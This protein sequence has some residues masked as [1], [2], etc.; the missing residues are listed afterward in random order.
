MNAPTQD[1]TPTAHGVRPSTG[2][3]LIQ[4]IYRYLA[5]SQVEQAALEHSPKAR[6]ELVFQFIALV[7][8]T[9]ALMLAAHRVAIALLNCT[10]PAALALALSAGG[11]LHVIDRHF[12]ILNRGAAKDQRRQAAVTKAR[13]TSMTLIGIGFILLSVDTFH[14]DIDAYLATQ[15]TVIRHELMAAPEYATSVKAANDAIDTAG[16]NLKRAAE[17]RVAAT[18]AAAQAAE[19][20][21]G[22]KDQC[23]G[24]IVGNAEYIPKCGPRSRGHK[25]MADAAI[26]R[27]KAI[28]EELE[29]LG[30]VDSKWADANKAKA[31]INEKIDKQANH[32]V[33]GAA[34][35]IGAL[36]ALLLTNASMLL[37][38]AFS[39]CLGLLPDIA[40]WVAL[41]NSNFDALYAAA[42][43]VDH[44]AAQAATARARRDLRS[45]AADGLAPV[46]VRAAAV[47]PTLAAVSDA[48]PRTASQRGGM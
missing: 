40:I 25:T 34:P 23:E 1:P 29:Q 46:E 27:G 9:S 16:A 8:S 30:D 14:E 48:D 43:K 13:I 26:E 19:A 17:L 38:M 28:K 24:N 39:L 35:K 32:A 21:K 22:W 11:T 2:S 6:N 45:R 7:L 33:S 37:A 42:N 4:F 18:S 3:M 5:V 44:L 41:S 15:K 12:L 20:N 47:G 31:A 10:W 36:F